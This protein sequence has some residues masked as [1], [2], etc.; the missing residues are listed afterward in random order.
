MEHQIKVD[1]KSKILLTVLLVSLLAS[2][3]LTY[4]RTMIDRDFYV[5]ENSE[6]DEQ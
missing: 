5:T 1:K 6:V 2:A 4:K 3:F